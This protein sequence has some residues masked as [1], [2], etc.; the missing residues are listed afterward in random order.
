MRLGLALP[1]Y[2]TSL[3][4]APATWEGVRRVARLAESSGFS[5]VW[6]SDHLFLDWSKYGGPEDRQGSLEAWTTMSAL[7]AATRKIRIGS[8]ALCND[9]RNPALLAKMTA[10]LDVVSEG[11]VDL[12]MGAGW[13]EPEYTAAGIPFERPGLRIDRLGEATQ[14]LTR[15]LA[16]EELTF[17][18]RHYLIDGAL[19]R[20]LPVQDPRPPV[21]LGGK[22]DRLISTAAQHADGWNFSWI[23]SFETYEQRAAIADRACEK[24][25]RDPA[26]LRRSVGAY[27]LAGRD[28]PDARRRFDRLVG[29]TPEGVLLGGIRSAAVSW[30]EFRRDHVAGSVSEVVDR[31][32]AF[33]ELGVEEVVVTVGTLP[34][35]VSDEEDVQFIGEEVASAL[36]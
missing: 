13:Y 14:I 16:G 28:D 30:E 10:S 19:C 15:M 1:H 4:G 3:A 8:L 6:I 35:Q 21:W 34:F 11:R 29:V 5:S 31:L 12:A 22:G 9:F 7:A 26:S 23:G 2:D 20:P 33:S 25:D 36:R 32:G 17:E 18:G 27:V 24:V